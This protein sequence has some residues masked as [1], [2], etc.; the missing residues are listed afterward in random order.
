MGKRDTRSRYF[1]T[2]SLVPRDMFYFT[3]LMLSQLEENLSKAILSYREGQFSSIRAC[4]IAFSV[5]V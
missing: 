2:F 4:A 5:L 3:H 1:R